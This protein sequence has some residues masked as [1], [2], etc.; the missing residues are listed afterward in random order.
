MTTDTSC[1]LAALLTESAL[2]AQDTCQDGHVHRRVCGGCLL[3]LEKGEQFQ[4]HL[5]AL[6]LC[7]VG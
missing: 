5:R 4:Y 1:S 2:Q 3:F 7:A 6:R